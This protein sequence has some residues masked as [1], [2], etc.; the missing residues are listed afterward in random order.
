MMGIAVENTESGPVAATVVITTKNRK[1]D[2]RAALASCARQSVAVEMLV[3]DDGS[4]D[5]TSAMVAAEFPQATLHRVEQSL[6]IVEARNQAIALAAAPIA[7]TI[8]DDCVFPSEEIVRQTVEDFEHPRVGAVAIPSIDVNCG[9][10]IS[11][12]LPDRQAVYVCHQFRGGANAMRRDVFLKLHG[13]RKFLYRQGEEQDYCLRLLDA[14]YVVRAGRA[15][16]IHHFEKLARNWGA[17]AHYT[18]RNNV[19]YAW[20]NVPMPYFPGHL[21]ATT[22]YSVRSGIRGGCGG[23]AARGI[24]AGYAGIFHELTRR[25]PVRGSSYRLMRRLR[26]GS[27]LRLDAIEG[28]LGPIDG[29]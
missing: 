1:D 17:I 21:A 12:E 11:R 29:R 19:L 15:Q 10:Q 25:A 18:S 2:L 28:E 7:I 9:A 20:Y 6:G 24:L 5:G 3:F 26:S 13:Y 8:D 22:L 23:A 16:P 4:T 27:V 14:G